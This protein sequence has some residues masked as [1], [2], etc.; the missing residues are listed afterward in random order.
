MFFF[1]FLSCGTS[2]GHTPPPSG[3]CP[4]EI[5][6]IKKGVKIVKNIQEK[7]NTTANTVHHNNAHIE[8]VL[9]PEHLQ[10]P[11]SSERYEIH[12][13]IIRKQLLRRLVHVLVP[14]V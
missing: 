10:R 2:L 6:Q 11:A 14:I 5:P 1:S 13:D 12:D 4:C 9:Q 8:T 3:A 7:R